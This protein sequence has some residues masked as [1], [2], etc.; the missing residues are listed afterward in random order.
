MTERTFKLKKLLKFGK[1]RYLAH[2]ISPVCLPE[3]DVDL[4]EF[5]GKDTSPSFAKAFFKTDIP[6]WNKGLVDDM[7][8]QPQ[9]CLLNCLCII[10]I[11]KSPTNADTA[12][13]LLERIWTE[14]PEVVAKNLSLRWLTSTM[15]AVALG[16][17]DAIE[18][19]I[20][21]AGI[22]YTAMIKMYE[23]ERRFAGLLPDTPYVSQD[24]INKT[25]SDSD[26]IGDIGILSQ[27]IARNLNADIY[28]LSALSD[29]SGVMLQ[30][31]IERV[32][33]HE[34]LFARLDAAR[35]D[36][37]GNNLRHDRF[38]FLNRDA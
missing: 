1:R 22:T 19:T 16:T 35:T 24:K 15:Q 26:D 34:T 17:G 2:R 32:S 28:F 38:C 25:K 11:R 30:E 23:S 31:I 10:E 9:L 37:S 7:V 29:F 3:I 12:L 13:A 5:V 33:A 27:D 36:R 21:Y 20:C 14:H 6:Q 18:K 4:Q 8:G